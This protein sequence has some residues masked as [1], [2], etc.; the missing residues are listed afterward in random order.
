MKALKKYIL[1]IVT[2]VAGLIF[3]AMHADTIKGWVSKTGLA[4]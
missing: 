3:G 4:L 2:L 1:P